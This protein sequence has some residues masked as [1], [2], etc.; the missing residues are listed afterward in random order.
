[1]QKLGSDASR[2]HLHPRLCQ[3]GPSVL[4][5]KPV[6]ITGEELN[7]ASGEMSERLKDGGRRSNHLSSVSIKDCV[8]SES[9][10][11][12]TPQVMNVHCRPFRGLAI[13]QSAAEYMP[14]NLKSVLIR[15]CWGRVVFAYLVSVHAAALLFQ[16][17]HI[18]SVISRICRRTEQAA[19][20]TSCL[21]ASVSSPASAFSKFN[22]MCWPE[23]PFQPVYSW[24][25]ESTR[26][27]C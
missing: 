1:M 27:S 18:I 24:K 3:L 7:K 8:S 17:S 16:W 11:S 21:Q 23:G 26:Q 10:A 6:M 14:L 20:P 2:P 22:I 9:N 25:D 15:P 13:F 12:C 19:V 5:R 4:L